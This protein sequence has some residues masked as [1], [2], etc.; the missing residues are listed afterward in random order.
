MADELTRPL[1]LDP[2]APRGRRLV[3]V[4]IAAP[5]LFG[6]IGGSALWLG[7]EPGAGEPA[8]TAPITGIAEGEE[9]GS[10]AAKAR[11]LRSLDATPTD[12]PTPTL[13]EVTPDGEVEVY[14]PGKRDQQTRLAAV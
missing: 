13:T 14:E 11:T 12:P 4:A 10:V 3:A 7:R 8:A 6:V 2:P 9:T 5:L 1:G